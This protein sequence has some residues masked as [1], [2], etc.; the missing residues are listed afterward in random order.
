[1]M[2]GAF[3]A[4]FALLAAM[5][6]ARRAKR[7][8]DLLHHYER[9][10]NSL[11]EDAETLI[12]ADET[13]AGI[14]DVVEFIVTKASERSAAREFLQALLRHRR[15]L[16]SGPTRKTSQMLID[17]RKK[18]PQLGGVFSRAMTSGLMAMTY[19]GGLIGTFVRHLV[20]FDAK[21]HNDRSQDLATSFRDVECH[22]A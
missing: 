5:F 6:F 4:V 12:N 19:N 2:E 22:A 7:N 14:V 8:T 1:M 20:L 17:F 9:C 15:E 13:P 11:I 16:A 10:M 21:Q 18:N 3:I